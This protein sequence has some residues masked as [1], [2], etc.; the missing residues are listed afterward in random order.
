MQEQ[1]EGVRW[2]KWGDWSWSPQADYGAGRR[3]ESE[4]GSEWRQMDRQT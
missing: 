3:G 1:R 2:S 4:R